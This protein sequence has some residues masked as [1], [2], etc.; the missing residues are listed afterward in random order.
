MLHLLD[1]SLETF[2][3]AV[4]PL[5]QRAVDVVFDAPDGDWAAGVSR[6]TVNLY[7]WDV[8]PNLEERQWGAELIPQPDGTRVRREPLPRV[9][10]RYLVTAWTTEVR[11]E[12]SLLGSVLA[13]L[14]LHPV[15][16]P[17][18]LRGPFATVRPLPTVL[19]RSGD[20]SENSD[21]WSALGGQL[22]PGLDITV[23]ATVD[24]AAL[25]EVGPPVAAIEIRATP[26][27]PPARA[28]AKDPAP[29][30]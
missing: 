27:A 30:T 24:A 4:V 1:E 16:Q 18:H 12:H 21:F 9:D 13:A 19:L 22:K 26:P 20:G 28:A 6:P 5:P 3:R 2:L 29:P 11:D 17:E 8:R 15:I 23:T 7:L 25:I 14:L 10:L